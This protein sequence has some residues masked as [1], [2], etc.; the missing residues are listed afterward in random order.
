MAR[1]ESMLL[2]TDQ[3]FPDLELQLASGEKIVLPADSGEDYTVI[4]FYRG[5]W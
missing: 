4:F 2:D 1:I 5:Y 3:R